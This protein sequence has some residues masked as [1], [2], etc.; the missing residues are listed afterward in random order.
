MMNFEWMWTKPSRTLDLTR[1]TPISRVL[2]GERS[3]ER[4]E[5]ERRINPNIL[6]DVCHLG[7][8]EI[9]LA[10]NVLESSSFQSFHHELERDAKTRQS[11]H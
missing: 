6:D 8:C 9:D 10:D 11:G 2:E 4:R 7:F 5:K 1:K 3:R